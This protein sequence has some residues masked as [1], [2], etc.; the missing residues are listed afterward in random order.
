VQRVLDDFP[1]LAD[2]LNVQGGRLSGGE[3]QLLAIG[4]ALV[5][6]PQL[7]LLDEPSEGLA[8][9]LVGEIGRIL[10]RLSEEGLSILLVEQNLGLALELANRIVVMSKGLIVF[11]GADAEFQER[12]DVVQRYLGL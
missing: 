1:I 11:S 2:R 8:P 5:T 10:R 12:P 7:L 6:N 4:R 3:Q 9:A